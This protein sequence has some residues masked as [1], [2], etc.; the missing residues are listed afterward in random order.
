[1]PEGR[2]L[3]TLAIPTFSRSP[4]LAELLECLLPQFSPHTGENPT[5]ELIISDNASPDDTR[6]VVASFQQRGLP[7]KYVCNS[8]NIGADANFLQ[9]LDLARGKYVW[10]MGD[11][12]LLAPDAIRL[13]VAT[14]SRPQTADY[15]LIYLSSAGFSGDH[16]PRPSRDPLGRFAEVITDGDYFLDKVNALIGL[17]SANIVNK[18]R[19]LATPHPPITTL[20]DTNL[21]QV[22]WLFPVLHRRCRVLYIF[23]R[24]VFYRHFNSGGWGICEVFG[25]RLHSIAQRYFAQEPS[26]DRSLMNG[27]LRHWLPDVILEMRRGKQQSMHAED[28]AQT[29]APVFRANWRYWLFVYL[30]S[31]PPMPIARLIH[32]AHRLINKSSRAAQ[33]LFRHFYRRSEI[34]RPF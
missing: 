28:F 22:G 17:I 2:P 15:D 20:N 16:R 5:A 34:P 8:E 23:E 27:V 21:I 13:L 4:Y 33:G 19:L 29:L 11:D 31:V 26:L 12:D 9:C 24:L 30:V 3:L 32:Q 1:M 6:A 18:D 10:V 14:L 7:C 25:L